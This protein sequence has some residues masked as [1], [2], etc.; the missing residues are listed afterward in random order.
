MSL[1]P[2]PLSGLVTTGYP[3]FS[4]NFF[5]FAGVV[6]NEKSADGTSAFLYAFF[7]FDFSLI[8][9]ILSAFIPVVIL[10]SERSC[11]SCASQYSLL[12]SS[13]SIFPYL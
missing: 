1:A 11:A 6:T 10:K 13:Q 5:A 12:D 4:I 7:I 2:T 8:L 9:A 3:T